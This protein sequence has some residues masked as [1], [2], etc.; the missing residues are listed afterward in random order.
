MVNTTKALRRSGILTPR[1]NH[2][3]S[4]A[5]RKMAGASDAYLQDLSTTKH[6]SLFN[7]ACTNILDEVALL[8]AKHQKPTFEPWVNDNVQ[9]LRNGRKTNCRSPMSY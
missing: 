2:D 1:T 3:F 6:L 8:K 9:D 7:T 4:V 5:F